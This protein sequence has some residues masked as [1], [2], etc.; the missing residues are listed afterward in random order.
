MNKKCSTAEALTPS[1]TRNPTPDICRMLDNRVAQ[2]TPTP[3]WGLQTRGNPEA[4][5]HTSRNVYSRLMI[6]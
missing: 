1:P 5:P 6:A 3:K 4:S 2:P